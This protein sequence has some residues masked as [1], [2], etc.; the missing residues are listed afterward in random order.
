MKMKKDFVQCIELVVRLQNMHLFVKNTRSWIG[1]KG[2]KVII[3]HVK[4][5][6]LLPIH[7]ARQFSCFPCAKGRWD[8]K[9]KQCQA[10]A[11]PSSLT[12]IKVSAIC[13]DISLCNLSTGFYADDGRQKV[14]CG[15]RPPRSRNDASLWPA[16]SH[17]M[18]Q[19]RLRPFSRR[20]VNSIQPQVHTHNLLH[21]GLASK[22]PLKKAVTRTR[23]KAT[24]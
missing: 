12:Q 22:G 16:I 18:K 3:L 17:A 15:L 23:K 4:S 2:E 11:T 21:K 6:V 8:V 5:H 20:E 10:T 19:N 7:R 9:E 24:W 14:I 13:C 1:K